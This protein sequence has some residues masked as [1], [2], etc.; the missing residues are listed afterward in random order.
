VGCTVTSILSL[1]YPAFVTISQEMFEMRHA[2]G[3]VTT[4]LTS[5]SVVSSFQLLELDTL[6][7]ITSGSSDT[8]DAVST[9]ENETISENKNAIHFFPLGD[10]QLSL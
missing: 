10:N 1:L 4:R 3:S 6:L 8:S 2:I 9:S 5:G 7:M